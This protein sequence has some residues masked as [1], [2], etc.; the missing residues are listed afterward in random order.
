M[1]RTMEIELGESRRV[2]A[3]YGAFE[4]RTDQTIDNGGDGSAPEPFDLFLAS[5]GTCAGFYVASF[6]RNREIATEGV[7]LRLSWSRD[8]Q[9]KLAG[10]RIEIRLPEEFP[11]KYHKAVARAADQCTVKRMLARLRE[12]TGGYRPPAGAGHALESLWHSL[13]HLD[14]ELR[15][16]IAIED[17]ELF[18]RVLA[19]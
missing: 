6:C 12:L 17:Q 9:G 13:A 2:N 16:H 15:D 10:I 14:R 3:R 5:L 8:G 19:K 11:A 4:L 18:P 7:G 1:T